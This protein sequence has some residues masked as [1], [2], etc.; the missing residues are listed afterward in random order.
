MTLERT[1]YIHFRLVYSLTQ[2]QDQ[3]TVSKQRTLSDIDAMA[4]VRSYRGRGVATRGTLGH[5]HGPDNAEGPSY[6]LHYLHA[7][8]GLHVENS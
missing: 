8:F 1:L 2:A 6:Y 5:R 7:Y 4:D 3:A